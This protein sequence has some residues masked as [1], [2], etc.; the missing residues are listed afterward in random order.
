M[1]RPDPLLEIR[2]LS[3]VR[4]LEST[5]RR[6]SRKALL[7]VLSSVDDPHPLVREFSEKLGGCQRRVTMERREM[8]HGV[9]RWVEIQPDEPDR[10]FERKTYFKGCRH[11]LCPHCACRWTWREADRTWKRLTWIIEK[12]RRAHFTYFSVNIISGPLGEDYRPSRDQFKKKLTK[13][14][15]RHL[16]GSLL[17]GSFHIN[18]TDNRL[19]KLH[20]HGWIH[21]R[22]FKHEKVAEV[23]QKGFP[24]LDEL[25]LQR[26]KPKGS[27]ERNFKTAL[28]YASDQHL[29]VRGLKLNTPK[30]LHDWLVSLEL[31]RGKGRKGL[32]MQRGLNRG[33][34][35]K[36]ARSSTGH[37]RVQEGKGTRTLARTSS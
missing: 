13:L 32:R 11:P 21:S 27:I 26:M 22:E 25:E 16:P 35:R 1:T 23:L 37:V 18:L 6:W 17:A 7:K 9:F 12:P 24:G 36:S 19:G 15:D 20:F 28:R 30:I 34:T 31:L 29:T 33:R 3:A 10:G 5:G 4:D 8:P 2:T 14:L